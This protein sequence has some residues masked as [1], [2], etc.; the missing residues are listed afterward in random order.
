MNSIDI[1]DPVINLSQA[2]LYHR[3]K[4]LKKIDRKKKYNAIVIAVSH[5]KFKNYLKK[6]IF[7][8]LKKDGFIYD[9]KSILTDKKRTISF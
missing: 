7:Q 8:N 1:Y 3:F 4:F 2:R 6:N 9:I 5:S